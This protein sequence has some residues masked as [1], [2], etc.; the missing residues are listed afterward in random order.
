MAQQLS[1]RNQELNML[2]KTALA[3]SVAASL[4]FAAPARAEPA[5]VVM[6]TGWFVATVAGAFI[7]GAVLASATAKAKNCRWV[8]VPDVNGNVAS[9]YTCNR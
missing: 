2:K 7:V 1:G 3:L 4:A 8:A 6:A 9:I 5:T